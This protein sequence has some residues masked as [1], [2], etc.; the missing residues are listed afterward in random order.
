MKKYRL[1]GNI[2]MSGDSVG[3]YVSSNPTQFMCG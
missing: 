3:E 1:I 2:K